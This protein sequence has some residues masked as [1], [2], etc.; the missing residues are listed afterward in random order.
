MF[1]KLWTYR[2]SGRRDGRV[3]HADWRV[4]R[5]D[6]REGRTASSVHLVLALVHGSGDSLLIAVWF[7][8][9]LYWCLGAGSRLRIRFASCGLRWILELDGARHCCFRCGSSLGGSCSN[10][11]PG[12]KNT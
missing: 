2:Q 8:L 4:P 6:W 7:A 10:Y 1:Q 5:T 12:N 11:L 9:I 3:G